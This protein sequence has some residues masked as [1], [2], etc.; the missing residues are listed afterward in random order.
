M[1]KDDLRGSPV[2]VKMDI[3]NTIVEN[4]FTL[5][6]STYD[7]TAAYFLNKTIKL[8]SILI[9]PSAVAGDVIEYIKVDDHLI[10]E[11]PYT[12]NFLGG[13]RY[14]EINL[15][16]VFGKLIPVREKIQVRKSA[17]NS[18]NMDVFFFGIEMPRNE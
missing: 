8:K 12:L 18:A 16:A 15:E 9:D 1:D 2:C 10:T 3:N 7:G 14:Y 4:V 17:T 5:D 13:V 11:V 6:T